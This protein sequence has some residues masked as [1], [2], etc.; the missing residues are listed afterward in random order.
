MFAASYSPAKWTLPNCFL[1][2]LFPSS[3]CFLLMNATV[4]LYKQGTLSYSTGF[5]KKKSDPTVYFPFCVSFELFIPNSFHPLEIWASWHLLFYF[6][7][8][9]TVQLPSSL[10]VLKAPLAFCILVCCLF[11]SLKTFWRKYIFLKQ[12][13]HGGWRDKEDGVLFWFRSIPWCCPLVWEVSPHICCRTERQS[14]N[15]YHKCKKTPISLLQ[16]KSL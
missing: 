8:S 13:L 12:C 5:T 16:K 3:F 9:S 10:L 6:V 1:A 14:W 11:F 2:S 15:Y 7:I 4:F